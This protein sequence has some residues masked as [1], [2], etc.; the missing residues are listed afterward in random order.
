MRL[1]ENALDLERAKACITLN[2]LSIKAK[3]AK[4]TIYKGYSDSINPVAVG[5]IAKALGVDPEDIIVKEQ[6]GNAQGSS[7]N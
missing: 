5:R 7:T 1:N 3:V 6:R 4:G 2:D